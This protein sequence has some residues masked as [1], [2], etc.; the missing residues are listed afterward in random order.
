MADDVLAKSISE[1][2]EATTLETG[3]LLVVVQAGTTKRVSGGTLTVT[4][5]SGALL[6]KNNLSELTDKPKARANLALGSLAVQNANAVA[7]SGGVI[8]GNFTG[9]PFFSG[10]VRAAAFVGNGA[11]LTGIGTGTGG[12]INTGS[13]T[14]GA[15]SDSD[16]VGVI[17]L[18]TKGTTRARVAND[19][20]FL[21]EGRGAQLFAPSRLVYYAEEFVS[22]AAAVAAIGSSTRATLIISTAQTLTANLTIPANITVIMQGAGFV[23]GAF[24]LI[25]DGPLISDPVPRFDAATRPALSGPIANAAM[26]LRS[27]G[28]TYSL[29]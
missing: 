19:G 5:T 3:D 11:G 16:G 18:Q 20:S 4:V 28:G 8:D 2:P 23:T 15:D 7:L 13:T 17:D 12:V 29:V 25:F 27:G 9:S 14:I 1:L 22:L 21:L 6:A 26:I 24:D 10:T